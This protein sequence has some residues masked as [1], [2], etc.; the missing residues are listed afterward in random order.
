MCIR[1][2]MY[3]NHL[4]EVNRLVKRVLKKSGSLYVVIGDTYSS[5]AG[6]G[7]K[8]RSSKVGGHPN[9]AYQNYVKRVTELPPK[10]LMG[11]PWRFAF[12]MVDD[13]WILRNA[14]IW[15]KPNH[16]PESVK[17]RLTKTYEFVFHFVKDQRYYYN[18]DMIR[19]PYETWIELF[20]RE[21]KPFGK[22]G[23]PSY[24]LAPVEESYRV[25]EEVR[26]FVEGLRLT[27]EEM[28]RAGQEYDSKYSRHE[29]GQTLQ[30]FIREQ[31]LAK[32]REASRKVAKRLFPDSPAL[33]Q[34]FINWVH[35][36]AGSLKGKN[37]GDLWV[38]STRPFKGAHFAVY[39]IDLVLRPILSSC[40]PDGIVLDPMCG[41][42]TTLVACELINRKMW[43]EFKI[44]VNECA[45]K[46]DWRL[47]WI[48]IE[49]N[50]EYAK[51]AEERLKPFLAQKTLTEV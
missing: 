18:L 2:S 9:E 48:G 49:I 5:Q 30:G 32:M 35:D 14:I 15:Y 6:F 20:T 17:D 47:K 10:C 23:S 50:P 42:G 11:I 1:D 26:K 51:I 34:K 31:S 7:R 21:A 36:H 4:I 22:K 33:Q 12:A 24:R 46:V 3:I 28:R 13:G 29:Y 41:S 44:Q 16:M 45:R 39:P 37:P 19:E 43:D 8:G 40:P 38:I 27:Y 25:S